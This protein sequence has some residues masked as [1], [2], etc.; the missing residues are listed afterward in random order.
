MNSSRPKVLHELAGLPLISHVLLSVKALRP[1]ETVVVLSREQ[2]EVKS[3]RMAFT[4]PIKL[5]P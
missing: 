1:K 4:S 3:V 2:E 5:N